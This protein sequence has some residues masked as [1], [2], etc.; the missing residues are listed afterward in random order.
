MLDIF[1][2]LD[3]YINCAILIMSIPDS[4]ELPKS[5][6]LTGIGLFVMRKSC[7]NLFVEFKGPPHGEE[8]GI[9]IRIEGFDTLYLPPFFRQ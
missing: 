3:N 1:L 2:T 8:S 7:Y 6:T 5:E 4:I 9:D